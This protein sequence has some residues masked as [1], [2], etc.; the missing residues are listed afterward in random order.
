MEE[1]AIEFGDMLKE[2]LDR[3]GA[4]IDLQATPVCARFRVQT[5]RRLRALIA[6]LGEGCRNA[7]LA[8]K[9]MGARVRRG[10][11]EAI[12]AVQNRR[13]YRLVSPGRGMTNNISLP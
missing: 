13:P 5:S 8:G 1:M 11:C 10:S 6:F 3:M 12:G 2:T 9:L 7:M 4:Q